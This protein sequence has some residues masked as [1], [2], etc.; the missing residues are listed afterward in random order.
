MTYSINARV[1]S[2]QGQGKIFVNY[3]WVQ[4]QIQANFGFIPYQGTL[5]LRMDSCNS[6]S[7]QVYK[8]NHKG[9][10]I[11]SVRD[12]CGGLCYPI[13]ITNIKGIIVI[14]Q[15]LGYPNTQLEIIA[16]VNL[17]KALSLKDGDELEVFFD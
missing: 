15:I 4:N 11:T 6:N 9:I 5:N 12:R 17:R 16:P 13:R 14:P 8:Q 1:A 7:F 2:G 3:D 10:S